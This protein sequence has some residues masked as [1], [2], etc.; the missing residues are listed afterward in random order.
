MQNNFETSTVEQN[1]ATNHSHPSQSFYT[2]LSGLQQLFN[3][4]NI[5][6][7]QCFL[8]LCIRC[9]KCLEILAIKKHLLK[10]RAVVES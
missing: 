6:V 5:V 10:T 8:A 2:L 4:P 7:A 9:F 3:T 1:L